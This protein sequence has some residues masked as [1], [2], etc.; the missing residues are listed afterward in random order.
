MAQM[1]AKF[2]TI[3]EANIIVIAPPAI[4]GLGATGG[5]PLSFSSGKVMMM[6]ELSNEM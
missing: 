5:L 1:Q 2:A 6:Y 3:K 4:P